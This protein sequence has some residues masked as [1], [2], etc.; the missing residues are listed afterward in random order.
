[1]YATAVM[2]REG[3]RSIV[4]FRIANE[5]TGESISVSYDIVKNRIETGA[6][7]INNLFID[8]NGIRFVDMKP[9]IDG[10]NWY[11]EDRTDGNTVRYYCI[12]TN[13]YGGLLDYI[14]DTPKGVITGE[15]QTFSEIASR[16]NVRL[17]KLKLYNAVIKDN[18]S[19]VYLN[20]NWREVKGIQADYIYDILGKDWEADIEI[21]G[22]D[23][24]TASKI[25]ARYL[26]DRASIP[27]GINY[28]RKF[29]G[30]VSELML[31]RTV[32][33][34]GVGCFEDRFDLDKLYIT[35]D[36]R[37]IPDR[38]FKECGIKR[39][40]FSGMED[41]IGKEAFKNSSLELNLTCSARIIDDYAFEN[42]NITR[43][44]LLK[45]EELGNRA[46][47]NCRK[48]KIVD[49]SSSKI[50]MLFAGTFSG[51]KN[52][53]EI[54]LPK[55]IKSIGDRLFT[56]LNKLRVVRVPLGFVV[57]KSIIPSSCRIEIY[58]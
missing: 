35:G 29:K 30:N 27:N 58:N 33:K 49:L 8:N 2:K 15:N 40:V 19:A 28:I 20:G 42:T 7:E 9:G 4:A 53:E 44:N 36:I 47:S 46:F 50:E 56:G 23:I 18:K 39:I 41:R 48:L 25:K 14:A 52:I 12:I 55:T 37:E 17:D 54:A 34:L 45:A 10:D 51:S 43:I 6:I 11:L 13:E 22:K 38:C 5:E 3:T 1:M 24:I 16:L 57:N 21:L 32:N 31:P 26:L